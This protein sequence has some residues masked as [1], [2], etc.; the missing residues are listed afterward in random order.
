MREELKFIMDIVRH[1]SALIDDYAAVMRKGDLSNYDIVTESD[2]RVERYL[3]DQIRIRYPH[4]DII[5]EEFNSKSEI[6]SSK[7]YFTIDPIDGT[8]NFAKHNPMWATQVACVKDG[9]IVA[10]VIY[11]PRTDEMFYAERGGGAYLNGHPICVSNSIPT[12]STVFMEK[13][14]RKDIFSRVLESVR[15]TRSFG[16]ISVC[17]AYAAAGRFDGGA[18]L[19]W[20]PWD[21]TPG[22]LLI[23]E[24]GGSVLERPGK[25]IIVANNNQGLDV[26]RSSIEEVPQMSE[27]GYCDKN[28]LFNNESTYFNRE[29]PLSRQH[30]YRDSNVY[31]AAATYSDPSVFNHNHGM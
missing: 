24:A 18:F 25:H 4:F 15:S 14:K 26:L 19:S 12:E 9:D 29:D 13:Q 2:I 27:N 1:S 20:T 21:V 16:S 6:P 17:L 7:N 28:V 10:S 8:I 5:S 31:R 22:K 23:E 11:V 3:I 30:T